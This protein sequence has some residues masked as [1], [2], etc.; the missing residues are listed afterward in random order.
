MRTACCEAYGPPQD[1]QLIQR[2]LPELKPD[3][4][5]VKVNAAGVG[6]VDGLLIQGKYQIK[7][8][9]PYY[10]GSE[11]AGEVIAVG[12]HVSHLNIAD[13]VMGLGSG[14]YAEQI[15]IH[16]RACIPIPKS[17]DGQPSISDTTAAGLVINYAT[18]LYGLRDC[19]NLKPGE[20]LLVLGAGGGVGTAA[21]GVA[22][23]MG[24]H[25]IAAASSQEKLRVATEAGADEAVLYSEPK[26]RDA[27]NAL[28]SAAPSTGLDMVYD[29]VGGQ[30]AEPALR[31]LAP[32]GRFLVVG[33]ASGNIPSIALNLALLKR[34]SIVGVDWGGAGRADPNLTPT[35]LATVVE[36]LQSNKLQPPPI[37]VRPLSD[38]RGALADQLQG[39]IYGKLVLD[40]Q[41]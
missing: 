30:V 21:I 3:E 31:S 8:P 22:K 13:R 24:A 10:P 29:P 34:C 6:F 26:W 7:P 35:L 1:L 12:S 33:F 20:T 40:C 36:W 16:A 37:S 19:G 38:V 15:N 39:K 5:R 4:V 28:A 25:V 9:L 27:V 2:E 17:L 41:S 14:T 18:A 11:F 32:G 23:A